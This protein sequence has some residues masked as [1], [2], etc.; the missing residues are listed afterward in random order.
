MRDGEEVGSRGPAALLLAAR[1]PPDSVSRR[2]L[3]C[4][5]MLEANG[6]RPLVVAREGPLTAEIR[7]AGGR[8][9]ALPL[10]GSGF[11]ARLRS[12][13]ALAALTRSEAVQILHVLRATAASF[14]RAA[15]KKLALPWLATVHDVDELAHASARALL[16]APR[17]FAVS[18]HV[19]E[20]LSERFG[21]PSARIRVLPP[22]IDL[23]ELSPERV[24]GARV[25][26]V[27]AR[28]GLDLGRRVLLVPGPLV[29]AYGH[30]VL[31]QALAK[32]A[33]ED[34]A[35]VLIAAEDADRAYVRE[36]EHA[37]RDS[38]LSGRVCFAAPPEDEP[39]AL[40]FAEL[41]VL[42]AVAPL[43]SAR[44]VLAAQAMGRPVI[45][46]NLGALPECVQPAS[47]GWV[48]AAGDAAE[49]A[50][51][52]ERALALNEEVRARLALRARAFIAESFAL[53]RVGR[54]LLDT[55]AEMAHEAA[56][57][58]SVRG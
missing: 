26:A 30:R 15:A 45:V 19:A 46:S 57:R 35:A 3:E 14:G 22:A 51:A 9:V 34:L 1:L 31:I 40:Q 21:V 48:V 47:T 2:T 55:Y 18:E 13:R 6:W 7:R 29:P 42:P 44:A 32:L 49:L 39:A 28:W 38:G 20:V 36:L 16:A 33:R 52:I 24:N 54:R 12:M 50:W 58:A 17:L 5:R 56:H 27:A 8:L 25:A 10:D 53:E 4:C 23:S 37:I 43:P 11:F 41:V